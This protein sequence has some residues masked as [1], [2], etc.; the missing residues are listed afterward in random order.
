MLGLPAGVVA[1]LFDLDGVVTNTASVHAKAW[2]EMFDSF[3]AGR[4]KQTGEKFVPFSSADYD[5]YVD[6][7]PRLDGTRSFL[8]A[9]HI[10]LPEG[11]PDDPPDALTVYGLSNHKND[12][13]LARLAAGGV[14]VYP[15]SVSY[16]RSARDHGIK[17]AIVSSSANTKQVLDGVGLSG[18][19][20]IRIDGVVASERGLAGKPAPDAWKSPIR[21]RRS[22]SP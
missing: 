22:A 1:C 2:K 15:G 11:A 17:T 6:G 10:D 18:L 5:K 13:V 16:I 21:S 3:L 8:Q 9:R 20:D 7:K 12:L 14:E 19:F 4:A